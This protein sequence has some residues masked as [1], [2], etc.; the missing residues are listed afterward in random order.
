M[1]KR[2]SAHTNA[3]R[4]GRMRDYGICQICGSRNHPEGHHA[5]DYQFGGA[6]KVSNIVTLC[7]SCHKKVHKGEMDIKIV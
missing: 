6:A 4:K 5:V 2:G 3:Q 1:S 7:R